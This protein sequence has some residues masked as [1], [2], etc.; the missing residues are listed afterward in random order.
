MRGLKHL[1]VSNEE[2]YELVASFTDAWI[3]TFLG[4][5]SGLYVKSHLLQMRGLKRIRCLVTSVPGMSHLLQMRG[6]K[7]HWN[8]A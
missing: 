2:A 7:R 6:L 5:C 3:E 8:K 1:E 4:R